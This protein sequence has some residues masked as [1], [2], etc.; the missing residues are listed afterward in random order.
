MKRISTLFVVVVASTLSLFATSNG[1]MSPELMDQLL[2]YADVCQIIKNSYVDSVD[3]DTLGMYAI[4]GILKSLDPHTTYLTPKEVKASNE[5][6]RNGF[7]GIGISYN[8]LD[9][10]LNVIQVIPGGPSD[11]AGLQVG[12]KFVKV[13]NVSVAGVKMSNDTLQKLIRGKSGSTVTIDILRDGKLQRV[14]VK[15]G[16]IPV[17]SVVASYIIAPEIGYVR[18]ERYAERTAEEFT[19]AVVKLKKRGAKGLILDLR[20]NGGGYLLS[21]MNLLSQFLPTGSLLLKTKGVHTKD[22]VRV[23]R[24]GY[25]K[26]V[27]D[28]LVILIDNYSASASE[29]TA[30]AVQDWDRG[31]IIGCRSY[32]KGLVQQPFQLSDG[33]EIRVTITRYYTPSGRSIQKP[34]RNGEYLATDSIVNSDSLKYNT[35][36]SGRSVYGGGGIYPDIYVAPDT[37]RMTPFQRAVIKNLVLVKTSLAYYLE[38]RDALSKYSDYKELYDKA[39]ISEVN[40]MLREQLLH[41]GIDYTDAELEESAS[42][43]DRY[44][45]A[46]IARCLWGSAAYYQILNIESQDVNKAIEVLSDKKL[47]NDILCKKEK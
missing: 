9:D 35:L 6:L 39:D 41:S 13:D 36:I 24:Y 31:V 4:K 28:P 45:K 7:D 16:H 12:D 18:I 30:G 5:V 14:G 34:Y 1:E 11:D 32:G 47:Y 40:K 3:Y 25:Q 23:A 17:N 42:L 21:A 22:A 29:I 46:L 2:K 10:T 33:S 43:F 37:T 8:V 19:D 20:G 38:N 27:D 15:R 26:F 44:L